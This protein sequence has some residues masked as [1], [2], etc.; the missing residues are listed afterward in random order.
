ME[1]TSA[2]MTISC[3]RVATYPSQR[4]LT[5]NGSGGVG[6]RLTLAARGR[7][8]SGWVARELGM[9]A[10]GDRA[11]LSRLWRIGSPWMPE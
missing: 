4:Q 10:A 8:G 1:S 3:N 6:D 11:V 7:R 9:V 2:A 5:G